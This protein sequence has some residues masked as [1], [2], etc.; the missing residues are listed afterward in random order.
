M[1]ILQFISIKDKGK[2]G[3]ILRNWPRKNEARISVVTDGSRILGLGDLGVNGMPISIGKISLYV[4]GAGIRPESTIPIC[5]DLGTD[6][7]RYLDDP[8]YLGLRQKRVPQADADAFMDELMHELSTHFPKLLVQFEDFATDKAFAYLARFRHRYALFNDDIQGTGAVVLSGFLNAAKIA[9]AAAGTPLG[10]QRILFL[11][12]GSAGVGVA[13]QLMSFFTLQG[14][15]EDMED[16]RQR[17]AAP[18]LVGDKIPVE[19]HLKSIR[20]GLERLQADRDRTKAR[21]E[22]T[23]RRILGI[24]D[25]DTT[26]G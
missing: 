6:T 20:I 16:L 1:S 12:A 5:L 17:V 3:Q 11:G 21:E 9:S 15:S 7:Q 22:E 2:I 23:L 10:D 18:D 13:M 14:M 25:H 24:E 26:E 19:V 4:A 8:L